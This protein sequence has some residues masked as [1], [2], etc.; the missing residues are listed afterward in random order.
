MLQIWAILLVVAGGLYL[1]AGAYISAKRYCFK[2]QYMLRRIPTFPFFVS[3]IRPADTQVLF[4]PAK[5][6]DSDNDED[7]EV[8][9]QGKEERQL[10]NEQ[11]LSDV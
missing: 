10:Q 9:F 1:L 7:E 4:K 6:E 2:G 8:V 11:K 3:T 5:N